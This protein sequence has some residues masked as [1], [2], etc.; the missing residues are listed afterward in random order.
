MDNENITKFPIR[1][2]KQI[3]DNFKELVDFADLNGLTNEQEFL[4]FMDRM[5]KLSVKY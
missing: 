5:N 1:F 3:E 4:D 2:M